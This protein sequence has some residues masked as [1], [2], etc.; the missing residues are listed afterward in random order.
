MGVATWLSRLFGR[1]DTTTAFLD[2]ITRGDLTLSHR[3]IVGSRQSPEV[4]AALRAL[5]ATLERTISRFEQLTTDVAAASRQIS[6]RSRSLARGAA[7][8]LRSSSSTATSVAHIDES[9]KSVQQSMEELSANAQETSTSVLQMSASIAEVSRI[10]ELLSAFVEETASSIAQMTA[11]IQ[12]VARNTDTFSAFAADTAQSMAGMNATAVEIGESARESAALAASVR[13]AASEGRQAVHGTAQ[14]MRRIESAVQEGKNVLQDLA[15]RSHE[16]GQIVRVIDEIA[17]QTN[18]LALNAAILA[19]QGSERG[20][21]FAVVADEIRDLSERTTVSTEEIRTLITNVQRGVAR[22][23]EQMSISAERVTEGVALT[24]RAE[25]VLENILELTAKSTASISE[26]AHATEAQTRGS[27]AVTAAIEKV[28]SMV[29]QTAAAAQQ[30]TQT[31]RALGTQATNV[32]DTAAQLKRA[33]AEQESGSNAIARAMQNIMKLV[34][35]VHESATVL[36]S[37]S[38]AI[39]RAVA[40]IEEATRES[41]V[42]AGDLHQMANTLSH[43]SSLLHQELGRFTLPRPVDGGTLTTATVLWQ[44]LTLDPVYVTAAALGYLARAVHATL[45]TYGEGAELMPGLAERWEIREQGHVYRLHL[46]RGVRFHNGRLL[47]ARDVYESFLRLLSPELQ[48]PSNWILRDVRGAADVIEGRSNKLTGVTVCDA[49]TLDIALE[50]PIAFFPSL[51]TMNETAIVPAEEARDR[52]R[53]RVHAAGAGPFRVEEVEEEKR[54]VLRRSDRFFI[55]NTPHLDTLQFRL[56]LRSGHDIAEAFI[57]GEIDIAHGIPLKSAN[58]MRDDARFAPYLLTLTQLHTSY[59][60]YDSSTGP[61]ARAEVRRAV[62]HAID[63]DRINKQLFDGIGVPAQSLLPPGLLGYDAA[64]RAREHDPERAHALMRD[65][66]HG[67]GFRVAY[68][69]WD[70]DE[71]NNSGM[72]PLIIEDLA[73]IGIQ[74]EVTRHSATE[75]RKPLQQPGH[76][77]VFCGNWYADFPDSDNFFY[78]FFHSESASVRGFYYNAPDLDRQIDDARTTPDVD[79]RGA[80]YRRLNRMVVEEAP[81]I[82]LF[83]ERFFIAHKP[84][85]RGVRTYLVPPPVRYGDVWVEA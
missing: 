37:E 73:R 41:N 60:G 30:Q 31:A 29:Q 39:V 46:R 28:T 43:E 75:A 58:A 67:D 6:G 68:R 74:V 27:A 66:G 59:F 5:T 15:D 64:L 61:F 79:H 69:T 20:R 9:I 50:A 18:L 23:G 44:Q 85:V 22:A 16:I 12:E 4:A 34:K 51:L 72:L 45:L 76:G 65:A 71:F 7:E 48:S 17:G 47:E 40:V 83:H 70:T 32:R 8:Q 80:I 77:T 33:M 54:V 62:S 13:T 53:Y 21:G 14:G 49:Q 84:Q 38:A 63:R 1:R 81:L 2:R 57:R 55:A 52:E 19:A 10:A 78:V 26:I 36:A 56:D 42:G 25:D 35:G 3:E 11:S 82:A 24:A